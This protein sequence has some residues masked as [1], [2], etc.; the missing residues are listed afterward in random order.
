MQ[1]LAPLLNNEAGLY[2]VVLASP[3][4][5]KIP[6]P[7]KKARNNTPSDS[8]NNGKVSIPLMIVSI[9]ITLIIFIMIVSYYDVL[10]EKLIYDHT[11]RISSNVRIAPTLENEKR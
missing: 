5:G 3:T 6:A 8:D 2:G 7:H 11:R 10:R 1:A 4:Q 9:V